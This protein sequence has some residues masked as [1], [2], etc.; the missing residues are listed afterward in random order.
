MSEREGHVHSI[1]HSCATA[2]ATSSAGQTI[3]EVSFRDQFNAVV[4]AVAR[5]GERIQVCHV[6]C[7]ELT[8]A[9]LP[10]TLLFARFVCG[11]RK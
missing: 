4:V 7:F 8:C 2:A 5:S 10:V 3:R 9:F 11:P 1:T 6:A